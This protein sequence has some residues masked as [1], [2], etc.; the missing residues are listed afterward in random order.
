MLYIANKYY[1]GQ[2]NCW[3]TIMTLSNFTL[4]ISLLSIFSIALPMDPPMDPPIKREYPLNFQPMKF[5]NDPDDE[6]II[7]PNPITVSDDTA[8]TFEGIPTEDLETIFL[9]A[10]KRAQFIVRWLK[11][12]KIMDSLSQ[13]SSFLIGNH[14]SGKTVLAKAIAFKLCSTSPWQYEYI[15]SR[16]FM[17]EY[18]HQTGVCLRSYLEKLA[19]LKHPTL[20]IID[21]FNKI[22]EYTSSSSDDTALAS[23]LI[24]NFIDKNSH[25][26]NIFFLGLMDRATKL[27]PRLKSRIGGGY[28]PMSEPVNPELKRIIFT[29]KCVSKDTPLD[30]E[31]TDKWLTSFLE[32]NPE[33]SGRN[34]R[35]VA[36]EMNQELDKTPSKEQESVT[37][38][39]GD[40]ETSVTHYL[41]SKRHIYYVD[42]YEN[43]WD[44]AER[45]HTEG[46]FQKFLSQNQLPLLEKLL[47]DKDSLFTSEQCIL[48]HQM[49][50]I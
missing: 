33:I 21:Q 47:L 12:E 16:A 3:R 5:A 8:S 14:G 4:L 45:V 13:Q 2:T 32:T 11:D 9:A 49:L 6:R 20:L 19:Q 35:G 44:R 27:D 37:I 40:I 15:S 29:S 30:P 50:E 48:I 25:N 46:L 43:N 38:T 39:R 18:R 34:Y 1:L 23:D 28:I 22:L 10:P 41:E 26:N 36:L 24:C 7:N 31:V 42:P 17:G